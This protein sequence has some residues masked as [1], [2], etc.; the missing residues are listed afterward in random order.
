[1]DEQ[2]KN[3]WRYY[4][5]LEKDLELTSRYVEPT[6]QGEVYSLEFFRIAMLGLAEAESLFKQLCECV[7]PN[8]KRGRIA[9]YK[10]IILTKFPRIIDAEVIIPICNK[11]IQPFNNWDKEKL[12]W[13]DK[14]ERLK[15]NRFKLL[16][17]A[18][19]NLCV[20]ILSAIYILNLYLYNFNYCNF[21]LERNNYIGSNYLPVQLYCAAESGLP[22]FPKKR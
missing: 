11:K 18:N 5:Y 3:N 10:D 2:I 13:W 15:H 7:K 4:L 9:N 12:E 20:E 6:E 19:Y 8:A 21:H 22:D 1:M 16:K 17:E 14:A